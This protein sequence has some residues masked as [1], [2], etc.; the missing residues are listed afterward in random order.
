VSVGWRRGIRLAIAARDPLD[1]L[2]NVGIDDDTAQFGVAFD[3]GV[4]AAPR[5]ETLPRHDRA[6][7]H[8]R[9]LRWL[10]RSRTRLWKAELQRLAD[11]T[12]PKIQVCHFPPGMS[13]WNKIERRLSSCIS[14]NCRA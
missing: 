11:D 13:K 10:Q 4:V 3:P 2:V 6:D 12:G 7:D 1:A 8:R 14:R 5:Q 9:R